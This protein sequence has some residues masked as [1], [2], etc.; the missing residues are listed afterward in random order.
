[1]DLVTWVGNNAQVDL[2]IESGVYITQKQAVLNVQFIRPD[3]VG[4]NSLLEYMAS[5]YPKNIIVVGNISGFSDMPE[6]V[7]TMHGM[8]NVVG[9][10]LTVFGSSRLGFYSRGTNSLT[11]WTNE[12]RV[13]YD[14]STDLTIE[15][16]TAALHLVTQSGSGH[17]YKNA[18]STIDHGTI[19]ADE[20]KEGITDRLCLS[21]AK[22]LSEKLRLILD[23]ERTYKILH[24][25]NKELITPKDIGAL[26]AAGG[27]LS[28][29][30]Q[31]E[32]LIASIKLV[33]P[34]GT[35]NIYRNA[36]ATVDN[37]TM[38]LDQTNDGNTANL[39]VSAA[40][41]LQSKVLLRVNETTY[42]VLHTGN[43][44]D[45]GIGAVP[46]SVE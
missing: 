6:G 37:G 36:N 9:T 31:I 12:W 7:T 45:Y 5:I 46:A 24:T 16:T 1:M 32:K 3:T 8:I 13:A 35:T 2:T 33:T 40:N 26:A 14:G 23:D 10:L 18:N 29:D 38:I 28:G 17:Y 22:P 11:A 43:M 39:I 15:K 21:A 27:T 25:G 19:M 42:T 30:L 20:I 34:L 41:K 4:F 44:T